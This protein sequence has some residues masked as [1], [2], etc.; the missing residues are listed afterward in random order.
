MPFLFLFADIMHIVV[1][2]AY[3]KAKD[4]SIDCYYDKILS[5][6]EP[7]TYRRSIMSEWIAP[8]QEEMGM[9]SEQSEEEE[10]PESFEDAMGMMPQI[11]ME[12][13]ENYTAEELR[14][15][16]VRAEDVLQIMLASGID[17]PETWE[18]L[19]ASQQTM[20]RSAMQ[21]VIDN[22]PENL[23]HETLVINET[24]GGPEITVR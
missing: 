7:V 13:L 1:F 24:E 22:P 5:V 9:G 12:S 14:E 10:S 3:I 18:E 16:P 2:L 19:D 21:E 15:Q 6:L 23:A 20:V 4:L 17:V 11:L 8:S